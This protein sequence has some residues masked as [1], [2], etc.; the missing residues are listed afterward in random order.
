[1]FLSPG[2]RQ[3][4]KQLGVPIWTLRKRPKSNTVVSSD[5]DKAYFYYNNTSDIFVSGQPSQSIDCLIIGAF[6]GIT[7]N[8]PINI[9]R[10]KQGALLRN[11]L[12]ASDLLGY[13]LLFMDVEEVKSIESEKF[14]A[15]KK[16]GYTD[17][18]FEQL[19][20]I[21]PKVIYAMGR[22]ASGLNIKPKNLVGNERKEVY[23]LGNFNIPILF[24]FELSHLLEDG[25]M[26]QKAWEDLIYLAEILRKNS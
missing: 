7:K 16:D 13:D 24:S 21:S 20:L 6:G 10:D 26:K 3:L 2:N 11:I 22:V 4:L 1:M 19:R 14:S 8:G 15:P 17:S 18:L 9:F 25:R 12:R 23:S 5:Q